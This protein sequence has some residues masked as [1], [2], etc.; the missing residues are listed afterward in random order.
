MRRAL[1]IALLLGIVSACAVQ[2]PQAGQSGPP[3]YLWVMFRPHTSKV[4]A[5]KVLSECRH[6]PDV[7]RLGPLVRF[8]GA[9]RGTV[10]TKDFGRSARTKPLLSCLQASS[11]VQVAAWPD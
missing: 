4:V 1:L 3:Y 5:A 9:L 11:S 10:W 6:Q 8:H 7:I 2:A